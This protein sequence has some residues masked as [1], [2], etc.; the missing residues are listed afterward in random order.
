MLVLIILYISYALTVEAQIKT[1][2]I[3]GDPHLDT[4]DGEAKLLNK[5]GRYVLIADRPGH[6]HVVVTIT[7]ITG[8]KSVISSVDVKVGGS[9]QTIAGVMDIYQGTNIEVKVKTS[10]NVIISV[11][12]G[13]DWSVFRDGVCGQFL[14]EC[15]KGDG[16]DYS[17]FDSVTWDGTECQYW[18]TTDP[19]DHDYTHL[20]GNYCR[21]PDNM[22]FPWCYTTKH[23]VRWQY[24]K[25]PT[26]S[27][28]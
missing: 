13:F 12:Q 25:L 18:N 27:A 14:P 17:G 11:D 15:I 3:S 20:P 2:S 7:A 6:L 26:C 9:K 5:P 24:C 23:N 22:K 16:T 28:N 8:A 21:N 1:C 10:N 4:F 19:H